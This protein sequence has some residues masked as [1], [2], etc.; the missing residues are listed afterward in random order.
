MCQDLINRLYY[1]DGKLYWKENYHN[2][3]PKHGEAG[4][5]KQNGY[6]EIQFNKKRYYTHRIIWEM[7]YG[8]IPDKMVIDHIDG[9]P[10]NNRIDN[11]RCLEHAQNLHASRKLT[12]NTSGYLGV[13]W[14]NL[15]GQ[16]EA[17]V[18]YKGK[19][20]LR[21]YFDDILEA[22]KAVEEVKKTCVSS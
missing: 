14:N 22:A 2:K 11:L 4:T 19:R 3:C 13:S 6:R 17:S 16:W 10:S 18:M 5:T 7:F 8:K 12:N 1:V 9:N 21:E 20:I 15:M